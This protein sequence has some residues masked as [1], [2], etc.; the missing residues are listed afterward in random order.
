M[1]DK[2]V[3]ARRQQLSSY[4][5]RGPGPGGILLPPTVGYEH[6]DP[7][8]KRNPAYS[9]GLKLPSTLIAKNGGIGPAYMIPKGLTAKGMSLGLAYTMRPQWRIPASNEFGPGP[10]AYL[11][12]I[13]VNRRK[14]PEYSLSMRTRLIERGK[15]SPGPIYLLPP[16]IG[17]KIPDKMAAAECSIKGRGRDASTIFRSPG[18]IYDIGRPDLIRPKGGEVTVK[19]RWKE[20]KS[21]SVNAGPGSYNIDETTKK[22]WRS[23]PAFSLGIRHSEFAGTMMTDCDKATF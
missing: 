21:Q 6:H 12:N 19:G 16:C 10:G 4:F 13:N 5:D 18:P 22:I 7:S 17:P 11:P 15:V 3:E 9:L 20:L 8:R 2:T 14:A 23:P 1:A